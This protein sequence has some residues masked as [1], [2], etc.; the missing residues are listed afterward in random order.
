M[1]LDEL[2]GLNASP[3]SIKI[4]ALMRY[5]RIPFLWKRGMPHLSE[6]P[7]KT[8][9]PLIPVLVTG[10]SQ[11]THVDST[12]II[13]VLENRYQNRSVLPPS[14]ALRFVS[15]LIEDFADEWLSKP[16]FFYRWG[17]TESKKFAQLWVGTE[18]FGQRLPI[19]VAERTESV[20]EFAARQ[21]ARMDMVG[22][23]KN[24]RLV[25][26]SEFE[27]ILKVMLELMNRRRYWLGSRPCGGD[28]GLYGQLRQ[29]GYDVKS[30]KTMLDTAPQVLVWLDA[31]DDASGELEGNWINEHDL[32]DC[33]VFESLLT[34][35]STGYARFMQ[36]NYRAILDGKNR[37]ET[38]VG[39]H[40]F[41]QESSR[42]HAKCWKELGKLYSESA[43]TMSR[44]LREQLQ[45]SNCTGAS[46]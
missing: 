3:Y 14:P 38:T 25:L 18:V 22:S 41:S 13:E 8:K 27:E 19:G 39:N 35:I 26:E 21:I 9:L 1:Q 37:V 16:M 45:A 33:T 34:V 24:N 28:F 43:A 44:A 30:H 6:T 20:S 7:L 31:L 11:E 23:G 4:R 17:N 15:A 32:T 46:D 2:H 10:E 36:A 29:L 42:Y 12:H 40:R 5:R